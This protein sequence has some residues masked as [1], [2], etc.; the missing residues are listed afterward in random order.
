MRASSQS[1][2]TYPG[3]RLLSVAEA[4]SWLSK[5]GVSLSKRTAQR[6]V[7]AAL[8]RVRAGH[9]E[10]GDRQV[11]HITNG[12]LAPASW[13]LN[14]LQRGPSPQRGRPHKQPR[15]ST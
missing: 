6:R 10:K 11:Q 8:E 3:N 7:A 13:W 12:Y 1:V 15:S 5:Q 9:P 2:P 14:Q 4:I